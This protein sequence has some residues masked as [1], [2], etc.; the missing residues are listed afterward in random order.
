MIRRNHLAVEQW[1]SLHCHHLSMALT[2]APLVQ[3]KSDYIFDVP[4]LG[5][6]WLANYAAL[7][8]AV[9]EITLQLQLEKL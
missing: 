8:I 7:T 4:L 6:L 5:N 3:G 2:S 9:S 1:H